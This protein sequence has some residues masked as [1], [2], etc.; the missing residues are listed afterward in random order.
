M[1]SSS[2]RPWPSPNRVNDDR[3]AATVLAAVLVVALLTVSFGG[4]AIGTAVVARHRAQAAADLGALA[5]A[6]R[7]PAG[8]SAACTHAQ[9]VV[10]AMRAGLQRCDLLGLDVTVVVAVDTGLR[11]GGQAVAT[12]RAGPSSAG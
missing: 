3:G 6:G 1:S 7:I 10:T 4:V 8:V 2:D 5:A 9:A 12:A 11:A